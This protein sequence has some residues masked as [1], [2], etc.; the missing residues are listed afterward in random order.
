MVGGYQVTQAISAMARLGLPARL[1][2]APLTPDD[3]AAATSTDPTALARLLRALTALGLLADTD[4]GRVELTDL[5]RLLHPDAPDSLAGWA[6]FVT[7]PHHWEAWGGLLHSVRT[8]EPAFAAQH[9]GESVWEWRQRHPDENAVFNEAMHAASAVTVRRL[10]EAYDFAPIS[11]LADLGGGDGTLMAAVLS[12]HPDVHGIVFDLPHVVTAA[13]PRLE[14]AGVADRCEIVAGDFF[15]AIPRGCGAYVL[16]SILHDWDDDA[17]VRILQRVHD[18]AGPDGVV[19]IVERLLDGPGA[20]L[21]GALSDLNM[22]V[23]TG[24]RERTLDSWRE[25]ADR[26]GFEVT[27]TV[28]LG[29]GWWVVEARPR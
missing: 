11:H 2:D 24:G 4:D 18:A 8:G 16:K 7:Q 22:M 25:L 27:G 10:A 3:L 6:A 21:I 20:A 15:A 29:A 23:M 13:A 19:L 1:A 12:R 14:A 9:D 28:E 5:G 17:S 26:G